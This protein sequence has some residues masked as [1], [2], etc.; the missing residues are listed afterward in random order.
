MD[1]KQYFEAVQEYINNLS[2]EEMD[3]LLIEAGIEKCPY[4]EEGLCQEKK[5]KE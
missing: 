4:E 5:G 2:E 3:Q 1:V